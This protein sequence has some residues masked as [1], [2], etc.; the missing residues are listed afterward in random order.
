MEAVYMVSRLLPVIESRDDEEK[1]S[2]SLDGKNMIENGKNIHRSAAETDHLTAG[3]S[4]S[5]LLLLLNA[6]QER[7]DGLFKEIQ[8]L[9]QT[10]ARLRA[11]NGQS[12]VSE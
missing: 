6:F 2:G 4:W 7:L 3:I 10:T 12:A 5:E 1:G 11:R 9:P 8:T